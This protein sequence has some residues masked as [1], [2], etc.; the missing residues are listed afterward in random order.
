LIAYFNEVGLTA[1]A[2]YQ[3]ISLLP[4]SPVITINPMDK[5]VNQRM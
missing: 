3:W 2:G 4:K 1:S 5:T